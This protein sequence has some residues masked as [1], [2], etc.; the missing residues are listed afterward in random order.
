MIEDLRG[1]TSQATSCCSFPIQIPDGV[2]IAFFLPEPHLVDFC[3]ESQFL[4]FYIYSTRAVFWHAHGHGHGCNW[5]GAPW[6]FAL[7]ARS[8]ARSR[9]NGNVHKCGSC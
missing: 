1:R 5:V 6:W 8:L 4:G 3:I 9:W 7:P 2:K